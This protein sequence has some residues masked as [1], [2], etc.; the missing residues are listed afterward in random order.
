MFTGIVHHIGK[1]T[2]I[3]H[4]EKNIH[5]T[6]AHAFFPLQLGESIAVDGACLTVTSFTENIFSCKL[7]SETLQTTIAKNY[8]AHQ[9]VNLERAMQLHDRLGGHIVTGHVDG[10]LMVSDIQQ[11][12]EFYTYQFSNIPAEKRPLLVEKGCIAI[13]GVS[14]TINTVSEN[15]CSVMLIPHTLQKTNLSTLKLGDAVN[16]EYDYL[17]KLIQQRDNR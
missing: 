1:I 8:V 5:L 10:K 16:V 9:I 14:L 6:I 7:S 11:D 12:D 2:S 4:Q 3:D 13:N 15:H 17:A